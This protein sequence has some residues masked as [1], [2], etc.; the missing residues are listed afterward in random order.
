MGL[1]EIVDKSRFVHLEGNVEEITRG[2]VRVN[3]KNLFPDSG[4]FFDAY[5]PVAD[6]D[7]NVVMER[8]LPRGMYCD[9]RTRQML[10]DKGFQY[11]YVRKEDTK[12]F[13]DYL[14]ANTKSRLSAPDVTPAEKVEILYGNAEYIVETAFIDGRVE[15]A[16]PQGAAFAKEAARQFSRSRMTAGELLKIFSKDYGTFTH[17]IQVS[18]LGMAF[19]LYLGYSEKETADFG[20][21]ALFHDIGKS[22]VDDGILNKPSRLTAE[23]FEL[24]KLHP[25]KGYESLSKLNLLTQE[26]L[27][28]VLQQHE[29]VNGG[30]YPQGLKSQDIHPYAK[31][32]RIVDTYD[33]LTTRRSYKDAFP[34]AQAFQLMETEMK[35]LLDAQLLKSFWV[36][37]R[38]RERS[39][40]R[41]RHVDL[42]LRIGCVLH[43]KL[44]D[45]AERLPAK[46]IGMDA[47]AYLIVQPQ[48]PAKLFDQVFKGKEVV[49]RYLSDGAIFGFES[50]VMD[51]V[52][53]P[54]RLLFLTYPSKIQSCEIREHKRYDCLYDAQLLLAGVPCR[55]VVANISVGGCQFVTEGLDEEQTA[56][57]KV[58]DGVTLSFQPPARA[59]VES[60]AGE[61]RNVTRSNGGRSEIG[62]RFINLQDDKRNALVDCLSN[63]AMTERTLS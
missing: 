9:R 56:R 55:G 28:V 41:D 53:Q 5:F 62:I 4:L 37:M 30:G 60:L 6:R 25:L 26:Q 35:P 46:L 54:V 32:T 22:E 33:A 63:L 18:L 14:Q 48:N 47:G 50:R 38:I 40:D 12:A 2:F 39:V 27:M 57:I 13:D 16:L 3:M 21:G 59:P 51:F 44:S 24:I 52:M 20:L 58:E 15:E 34:A 45:K 42:S 8:I 23:E 17:S 36:F 1:T 29:D 19:C 10:A 49:V 43:I 11:F 7:Y 31:I 61:V